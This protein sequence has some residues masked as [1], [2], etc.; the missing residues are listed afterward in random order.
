MKNPRTFEPIVYRINPESPVRKI[1]R[2]DPCPCGSG[3]K[4][5][6]CCLSKTN[7]SSVLQCLSKSE[8]PPEVIN[9]F[10]KKMEEQERLQ[11]EGNYLSHIQTEFS[12]KRARVVGSRIYMCPLLETFHEFII[13][14]LKITLGEEWF[15]SQLTLGENE[16]HFIIKCFSKITEWQKKNTTD[17]NKVNDEVWGASPDGYS[18]TLLALAF[19]IYSL[20]HTHHLPDHLLNRLKTR[21]QYQGVRYEIAIAAIFARLGCD[22]K[23]LDEGEKSKKHCEFVA[24]HKKTGVSIVVEAKSRHRTGVIHTPGVLD[25]RKLLKGDVHRLLNRALEKCPGDMPFMIFI[26]L[27]SPLTPEVSFRDKRWC[28]D[29]KKIMDRYD[30]PSAKRPAPYNGIFITNYSFHYEAEREAS[31]AESL[32]VIPLH[33]KFLLPNPTFLKMLDA[34]L[35]GYR[36]VPNLE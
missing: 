10:R 33:S 20:Q 5:K 31:P 26:D 1:G 29:I 19:D 12:G 24:I 21:D 8:V 13:F 17:A 7:S 14:I 30:K 34:G 32:T 16:C 27:N 25:E 36:N 11:A 2:N 15:K 18:R 9:H 6:K 3:K 4:Y 22:I 28:K 35:N 23:F